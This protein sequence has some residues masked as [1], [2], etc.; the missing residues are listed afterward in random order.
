MASDMATG[1]PEEVAFRLM[2]KIAKVEGVVLE[3]SKDRNSSA[4]DRAWI[5]RTYRECLL[6][7]QHPQS[8]PATALQNGTG[9]SD[10]PVI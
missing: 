3:Q 10:D 9:D 5:I 1:S 8:D 6:V 4:A 2:E 7:V